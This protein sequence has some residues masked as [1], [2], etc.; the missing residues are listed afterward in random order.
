MPEVLA[1]EAAHERRADETSMTG[2]ENGRRRIHV[3]RTA[4]FSEL[5]RGTGRMKKLSHLC[6]AHAR[7]MLIK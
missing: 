7:R 2:N 3:R 5:A 1:A 4:A 6:S